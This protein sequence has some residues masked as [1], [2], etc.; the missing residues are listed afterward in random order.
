MKENKIYCDHCGKVLNEMTDYTDTEIYAGSWFKCDL[1]AECMD[2]LEKIVL[3]YCK[4]GG[5]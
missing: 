1:C 5:E 2:E 3:A 4:K